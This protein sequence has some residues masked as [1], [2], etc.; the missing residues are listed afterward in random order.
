MKTIQSIALAASIILVSASAVA[1]ILPTGSG[2]D[3]V[4]SNT[5]VMNPAAT[6]QAAYQLGLNRLAQ[7][8]TFSSKQLE[9]TLSVNSPNADGRTL[10]LKD[11]GYV[12]VQER[13][14]ANGR[15][16]YVSLLNIELHYL[17]RSS[18]GNG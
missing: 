5:L 7:L 2:S 12:I 9:L 13:M 8:K 16:S 17:E 15:I 4:G 3:R 18:D 1:D 6:K 10:H 11:G 14:D